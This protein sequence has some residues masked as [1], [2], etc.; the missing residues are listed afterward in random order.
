MRGIMSNQ[1]ENDTY[2]IP[3]NFV[4]TGTF[5]GGMFK[6][7]NVIEAGILS[8]AVGI[9]VCVFLPL[10]L[11]AKIIVLCLTALPIALFALIGISGESLFSFLVIFLKYLKNR[12]VVGGEGCCQ[13]E[14]V[15]GQDKDT[16]AVQKI[17]PERRAEKK[18][19]GTWAETRV[20]QSAG[21]V[22]AKK[23]R[24]RLKEDFPAEFDQVRGYELRQ[25]LRPAGKT[26]KA[27]V[28]GVSDQA[29]GATAETTRKKSRGNAAVA[30]RRS[31]YPLPMREQQPTCLNPVADYLPVSRIANGM[32]YTKDHRY[33]KVV[34]VVPINFLLRS[35]R[36]QRNII[37]SF[38]SYLKVSPVRLQFKVLTRKADIGR[39][40]DTVQKEMARET[41]EQCRLMQEDYL[42]FVQQ[43]S[44]HEAVT[45]RFFLIFEY[46]PWGNTRRSDDEG[47]AAAFLQGAV[48]TAANYLRQCGNEVLVP[49]N[50]DEFAVDV[51]Y[52]L[53][54]RNESA[55][56]PLPERVREVIDKYRENGRQ[57]G[58]DEI[59]AGEFFS[60][61][62]IDFTHGRHICIDGLY[63]A[64]L[65][66]PSDG[67]RVQVP[68]G[69][70]SLIV[71]AGDGIDMDLF[72]SRQPKEQIVQKVGQ[73][74][75]I[76]RSRIK[77][78]SDT[79]T[80]F[81][82]IDSAIRGGYFLKEGLANNEDFYFL[83]LLVTVTA[84]SEEDLEWKVNEMKKLLASQD[85]RLCTCHFREEQA[86]LA[87][88]PLAAMERGLYEKS[89]RNL[90][91]GGAAS[92][93]PFTSYEMCDDNGI[94]LG[95]NKYNS[96]LIIVD[97]FNS[98]VYK[99]ANMAILGT[100]GAGKTF[101]MQLMALRMRRKGIP[102]YIIAPLKGHEFH[103]ACAN[104]GGEFIQISPASPH[105]INVMEIRRVDHTVDEL[106]DGPGIRLSE[107]AEK[108]QRLHI[109]FSLLIPD[110]TNEERQ[111]LDEAL[112]LA[113]GQKGITHDN[114]S[115]ED[116]EH[117]GQ[118]REMPVLGDLYAILKKYTQTRRMAVILNRLVNGSASTFNQQT[119]VSLDNRY[120]VLDISSLTGDLLTVGMF[121]ALDFVWDRAK[122]DRTE[123]KAIFI[124]E[125][126]QLLSGAGAAGTRM[127][128]DFV[129]EIFK[130][131]RG[132]GGSA[133][134]ASQD[135][136]DFFN[137]DEGRFGKGIIN[138]SKTKIIL[139]LEDDEAQRVQDA[140][141]L[142][143]AEVLEVTHFERGNGL[144]STNNN[145]IM[146]EFKA[147]PLEKDLITTDRREL[148]DIV[149]RM[150]KG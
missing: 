25:K 110:M 141:R 115:L 18:V 150:R 51:L 147:S 22:K 40:M 101:T 112:V 13:G 21:Q 61:D 114:A 124:D 139:N 63:Y 17:K 81:D 59:P 11:T 138:N 7:R 9:P 92:C 42:R 39:H 28:R 98:A 66:V 38:V 75:R 67:Y 33:V 117:P 93:Y 120:T 65:L 113:Y 99:N 27:V 19:S 134:C 119:N 123:E 125:C 32:I 12:R 3:P 94:L 6:A 142:S 102:I 97:I 54:C 64:Y 8:V 53:L 70:L 135:L 130:T 128:G 23:S 35:A 111:L 126:W 122:E 90:L 96:S 137:L 29:A 149:E 88:L 131:I 50:E 143:D 104:V 36:E 46:E 31:P 87:S 47:E 69:W 52:N 26:E 14:T 43:I 83:N 34:E 106:L 140:L 100:S 82:D 145:N 79:N 73:Q 2:I 121:V 30:E 49:E 144:I 78:A 76:N 89:R 105:C 1:N 84:P 127:A 5:F 48:H 15:A 68:A 118:Y 55:G 116:P 41:N 95:V 4:D 91:T 77:D 60:P 103:R 44:S 45:R 71:N 37:Y 146:V 109:F 107:L 108:I 56:K 57:G 85:M 10:G 62:S 58:I 136:N 16:K 132:Y 24:N 86:F 72:L 74:L 133:I 129:L 20:G 80:D 148:K